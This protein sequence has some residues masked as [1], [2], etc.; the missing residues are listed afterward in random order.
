[1][2][3]ISLIQMA[4]KPR[5]IW[6]LVTSF[7]EMR[8]RATALFHCPF[9][10]NSDEIKISHLRMNVVLGEYPLVGNQL[11]LTNLSSQSST[12]LNSDLCIEVRQNC[13]LA[14][15]EGSIT[16]ERSSFSSAKLLAALNGDILH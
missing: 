5:W 13:S 15:Q 12:L 1:V 11:A 3:A 9:N 16:L 6:L 2:S 7:S 4:R 10:S 8:S 14:L